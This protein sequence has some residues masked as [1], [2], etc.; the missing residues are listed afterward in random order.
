MSRATRRSN[1]V[2]QMR[3]VPNSPIKR[4][5]QDKLDRSHVSSVDAVAAISPASA[6]GIGAG[7]GA[8][9]GHSLGHHDIVSTEESRSESEV[10]SATSG[11]DTPRVLPSTDPAAASQKLLAD[12]ANK[13]KSW[14]KRFWTTWAMLAAFCV[15][16]AVGHL[17]LLILVFAVQTTMFKEIVSLGHRLSKEKHLPGFRHLQWFWFV[18]AQIFC[19]PRALAN[20]TSP[21]AEGLASEIARRHSFIAF[22]AYCIGVVGFVLSLRKRFI[23]Y[24]FVMFAWCHLVIMLVVVQSSLIVANMFNGL[25]WF[26]MP[27]L[28]IVNNDVWAYFFGFFWGRTQLI[29]LSPKKTWEG[30]LGATF[31]TLIVGFFL[32]R[33]LSWFNFLTCAQP[34]VFSLGH[35]SCEYTYVFLPTAY[36]VPSMI[37]NALATIGLQGWQTVTIAPIQFHGM[38]L[39][40]F[41]S[42]IAPFGGFFAS[43]FKR[44][45]K[46]K[47]FGNSI[48]G[49]GGVTDRM[50]CQIMMGAFTYVYYYAFIANLSDINVV[51]RAFTH[52]SPND[53]L[54]A[55]EQIQ[56]VLNGA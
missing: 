48:P 35:I 51:V 27:A 31:T 16:V 10:P 50:D 9:A 11:P 1:A 15:L 32:P 24:Q 17:A 14:N 22:A 43:G 52:L 34:D 56:A 25:I 29:K 47:D 4:A 54:Q 23:K 37:A 55:F 20:V 36:E 6:A 45:F 3:A 12:Q 40:C 5:M 8:G 19:Y 28:L 38:V 44:A 33:V 7:A 18:V 21:F 41:A 39:A 26:I 53:Q 13:W 42:V 49:H 30:F 2:R 46:I